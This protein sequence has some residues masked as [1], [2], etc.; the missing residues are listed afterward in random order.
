MTIDVEL[1]GRP[2]IEDR[3][4]LARISGSQSHVTKFAERWMLAL[5]GS[6]EQPRRIAAAG[7]T[8]GSVSARA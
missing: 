3:D 8:A 6:A 7:P 2:Y 4:T 1:A 5:D